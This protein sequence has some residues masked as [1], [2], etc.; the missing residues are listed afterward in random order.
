M[1]DTMARTHTDE[2]RICIRRSAEDSRYT[3][4]Q[5]RHYCK[6]DRL[7]SEKIYLSNIFI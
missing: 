4:A 1:D 5:P 2:D 6:I 7:I 3:F